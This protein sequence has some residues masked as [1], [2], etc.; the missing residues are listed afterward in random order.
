MP[1]LC[2]YAHCNKTRCDADCRTCQYYVAGRGSRAYNC[3]LSADEDCI[4]P[5]RR[6][7]EC[8]WHIP[9]RRFTEDPR[10]K[11]KRYRDNHSNR[12]KERKKR[13]RDKNKAKLARKARQRRAQ[14]WIK[15]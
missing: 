4:D 14:K 7:S 9:D 15:N 8:V 1:C 11:Q 3:G 12:E 6:C 10:T 13:W 2:E 5:H